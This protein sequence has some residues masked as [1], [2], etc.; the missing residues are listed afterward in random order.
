[1]RTYSSKLNLTF[2]RLAYRIC[3]HYKT[4]SA[5][6]I[7]HLLNHVIHFFINGVYYS[8]ATDHKST[9]SIQA[10]ALKLSEYSMKR[11]VIL[12]V[13]LL[14]DPRVSTGQSESKPIT[15]DSSLT[16]ST[17]EVQID[18]IVRDKRGHIIKNLQASDFEIYE[19]GEL[20]DII[21]CQIVTLD[22]TAAQGR[23]L[24]TS[25]EPL[26]PSTP[27]G[28]VDASRII[29]IVFDRLDLSARGTA[30]KA[31]LRY[32]DDIARADDLIG[33]FVTDLTLGIVQPFTTDKEMVRKAI[34]AVATMTT[35]SKGSQVNELRNLASSQPA[36]ALAAPP[37][38][39][40]ENRG[41]SV[42]AGESEADKKMREMQAASIEAFERLQ[43]SQQGFATTNGLLAVI[44]GLDTAP[45]RKALL[46]FS[47]GVDIPS[48][49]LPHF[50]AVIS[51]ANRASVS[52]YAVDAA[53]LRVDP[54]RAEVMREL[55]APPS[56]LGIVQ[57]ALRGAER[58]EGALRSSSDSS[59]GALA[60]QTGGIFINDT[61]DPGKLLAQIDEDLSTHYVISYT[62]KNKDFDGQFR[63]ITVKVKKPGLII[64]SREGY[65]AISGIGDLDILPHE[66]RPLAF[67]TNSR[68]VSSFPVR[69]AGY[70]FKASDK[71]PLASIV[72]EVPS[73]AL[74]TRT[75]EKNEKFETDFTI[76]ALI[77]NSAG[78]IVSKLSQKYELQGSTTALSSLKKENI[79]FYRELQLTPGEY[80][81]EV[82]AY[83]EISKKASISHALLKVPDIQSGIEISSVVIIN[84]AEQLN[85]QALRPNSPFQYNN[86]LLYPNMGESLHKAT[87]KHVSFFVTL[88]AD[89]EI[90]SSVLYIELLTGGSLIARIQSDPLTYDNNGQL[91]FINAI[92]IETLPPAQYELR[93]S[94]QNGSETISESS[95]FRIAP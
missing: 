59:L 33:V 5:K 37:K 70:H 20:Q 51:A 63:T 1:M 48:T 61:N 24:Q 30:Q 39:T 19:A 72:I 10:S 29:A 56:Q 8:S 14:S 65:F 35:A 15:E 71:S 21:S 83:D 75:D 74:A 3:T 60:R 89:R 92:P 26:S 7:K 4:N 82:A 87:S 66:A 12:F 78:K 31:A 81:L 34:N 41:A 38:Y 25:N 49:V 64:R 50:Q 58:I 94:T 44:R 55:N 57:P 47:T 13:I 43:N 85:A 62:P 28:H 80:S 88:Y 68:K 93:I 2:G 46:F 36:T 69:V 42:R 16:I 9:I 32:V 73:N 54:S 91:Q 67:L 84:R 86:A 53:G 23:S 52:I 90:S 79:L 45:G 40:A 11:I 27:P 17:T 77:R 6:T 18:A 76:V 22:D 95:F